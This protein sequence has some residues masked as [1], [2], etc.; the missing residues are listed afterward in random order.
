MRTESGNVKR[1]PAGLI[2]RPRY[3]E[4]GT[5]VRKDAAAVA[6]YGTDQANFHGS[7]G[8]NE[9]EENGASGGSREV[10][11][12]CRGSGVG[13]RANRA[14]TFTIFCP[15]VWAEGHALPCANDNEIDMMLGLVTA[16]FTQATL[17]AMTW[18][19]KLASDAGHVMGRLISP[20][21]AASGERP[22]TYWGHSTAAPPA[23]P[24][25]DA[26]CMALSVRVTP[27]ARMRLTGVRIWIPAQGGGG[28]I[29]EGDAYLLNTLAGKPHR[30][31]LVKE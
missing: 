22:D 6:Q 19:T 7:P 3:F 16:A 15:R 25:V 10:Y 4:D 30:S 27:A 20:V 13:L 18:D 28:T 24:A 23:V 2:L 1:L 26:D 5:W 8:V 14:V 11:L 17:E 29:A 12:R 9:D 21:G 31:F